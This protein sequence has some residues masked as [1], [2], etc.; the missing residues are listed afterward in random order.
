M[1]FFKTPKFWML[2]ALAGL[3][4]FASCKK[5]DNNTTPPVTPPSTI[6]DIVSAS[7]NYTILKAAVI[8]AGL[9]TT[10]SGTG[11]FTV[12][13]PSDSAFTAA[14]VTL[15]TV[16]TLTADQLKTIL[17]YHTL[18]GEVKAANVPAGP[19][20][21]VVSAEGDSLYLT[22]NSNGVF[23]N[24]LRVVTA[25]I[26]ASNGVIHSLSSV[27]F[28]PVGNI[29]EVAQSDTT[30]SYLVAAVLRASQGATNVAGV[31]TGA[32]PYTVFA[33]TNN[34]FRAAGFA[35]IADINNADPNVLASILTYHVI[36]G[37]IF[38]S[39]LTN[40]ATP[41]TLNGENVTINLTSGAT[42][43]GKTNTTPSNIIGTNIMATNGV[44]HVIDQVLLP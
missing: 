11:P 27:L 40:G 2:T 22:N 38:S 1:T 24:G 7:P 39:D 31:L 44:V 32:G 25:D 14:G 34:A 4:T 33:P 17:L 43:K 6:T 16:N 20:A 30:F 42:V 35:T 8:K 10:L 37:R 26:S 9:A 18:S 36:A 29:V 15:N 5:K 3:L 23:V 21:P 12:F 19:N 13:A 28:P 41:G